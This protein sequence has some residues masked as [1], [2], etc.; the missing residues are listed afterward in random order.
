MGILSTSHL[1]GRVAIE[2][3]DV[4]RGTGPRAYMPQTTQCSHCGI[5][6][7]LPPGIKPGKRL[8]CP[9][10]ATRF[11]IT[12]S[13]ASSASTAPGLAD[14]TN[15]SM[16]EIPKR[17]GAPE[18]LP[19]SLGEGDLR[20]AFDLP[21]VSGSARDMERGEGV[22]GAQTADVG[23]LFED[24]PSKRRMTAAEA[25]SQA[26]RC[27][28]CGTGVPR[29]MSICTMCG[30]DQETGLRVGLEDDLAPPPPPPP[31]GPPIHVSVAGGLCITGSLILLILSM[32][33]TT[34]T[35]ST[36]EL[37][38]WLSLALVSAFGIYGSVQFLRGK[39]AKLLIV[40]LTLGAIVDVLGLVGLP[41]LQPFLVDAESI[42]SPIVPQEPDEGDVGILPFEERIN[43]KIIMAGVGLILVYV[44][45]ALYLISP[46]V[47]RFIHGRADRGM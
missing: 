4:I 40:A 41:L 8:K 7:N 2:S 28:T 45:F 20:E 24:R 6:L 9:R 27:V 37:L 22:P 39:S 43:L 13:D 5:I 31:Q 17:L 44:I 21:L 35:V 32:I 30:T 11:V 42:V 34:R 23:G 47:K 15:T 18:E 26:R 29:G 14:A 12:E 10:C 16:F 36:I 3:S 33:R 38:S 46:P 25:R 1:S 19:P